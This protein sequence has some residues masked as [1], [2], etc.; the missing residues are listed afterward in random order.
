LIKILDSH[1][2]IGAECIDGN[3]VIFSDELF[4]LL[5][6]INFEIV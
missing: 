1:K 4:S 5:Y 2:S 6:A 3:T